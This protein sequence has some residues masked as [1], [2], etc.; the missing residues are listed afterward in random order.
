MVAVAFGCL[1]GAM[2]SRIDEDNR[3]GLRGVVLR[4][5]R[6]AGGKLLPRESMF[7]RVCDRRVWMSGA[8]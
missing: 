8:E 5:E 2:L 3:S 4:N 1:A 6:K 7:S